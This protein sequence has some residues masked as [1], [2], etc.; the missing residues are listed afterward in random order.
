M[1][2]SAVVLHCTYGWFKHKASEA[3]VL[4]AVAIELPMP[5]SPPVVPNYLRFLNLRRVKWK[6]DLEI[7][8]LLLA[9]S[10][11]ELCHEAADCRKRRVFLIPFVD[12]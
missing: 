12:P 8:P 1:H 3:R 7:Q 11:E 10:I 2:D 6:I 9:T 4:S 5:K